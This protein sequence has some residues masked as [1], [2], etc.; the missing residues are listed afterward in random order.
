MK[1]ASIILTDL[2]LPFNSQDII[3]GGNMHANEKNQ[4]DYR[5]Q[6]FLL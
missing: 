2:Q 6:D 3:I 4:A 5:V 1:A